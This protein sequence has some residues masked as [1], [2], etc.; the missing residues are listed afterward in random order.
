MAA[1]ALAGCAGARGRPS[2][3]P[4]A[5]PSPASESGQS[6]FRVRYQGP[7]GEGSLRL[8]LRLAAADR[9]QLSA[10]DPFGRALWSFRLGGDRVLV[11]DHR[12]E[13]FCSTSQSLRI[14]EVILA[15]LP[16][17][18]LPRVLLGK[19]PVEPPGGA[20][21][22]RDL[23]FTDR[24]GNRWTATLEEGAA[25]SWTL[26][27]NAE[28]KLWWIRQPKGGILSHRDG[29]QFRWRLTVTEPLAD[30]ELDLD[31]PDGYLPGA[32]DEWDLSELREDQPAPAGDRPPR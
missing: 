11:V 14:P 23:D 29:A 19:L 30:P 22:S 8:V 4:A 24:D 26:W 20:S 27:E 21:D 18:V 16:P 10:S 6:L 32:C 7:R 12:A 25:A 1:L 17:A 15:T 13:T 9:F 2:A 5:V 31:I 28:P 3:S